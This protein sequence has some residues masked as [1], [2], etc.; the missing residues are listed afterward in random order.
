MAGKPVFMVEPHPIPAALKVEWHELLDHLQ[1]C[2][3]V[4]R[5]CAGQFAQGDTR[6]R[7][8]ARQTMMGHGDSVQNLAQYIADM[9]SG[10][11]DV[12]PSPSREV[13]T[14][15]LKWIPPVWLWSV[16]RRAKQKIRFRAN[17]GVEP[18]FVK[19]AISREEVND[20]LAKW[21]RLLAGPV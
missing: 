10:K 4:R 19:D 5:V 17:N 2:E 6:L 8:W 20:R 18:E 13:V 15:S 12:P 7:D 14:P 16:Y 3:D 21:S 9:L 11:L 1:T